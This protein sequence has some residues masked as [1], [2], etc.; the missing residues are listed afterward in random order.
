[1]SPQ[2]VF[3]VLNFFAVFEIGQVGI[4]LV[5]KWNLVHSHDRR[6]AF[7]RKEERES[8]ELMRD[9]PAEKEKFQLGPI[10]TARSI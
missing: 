1:V 10:L 5:V 6:K 2:K 3:S 8:I 4:D 7:G 9:A